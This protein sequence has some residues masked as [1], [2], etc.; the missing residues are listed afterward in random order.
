MIP[1]VDNGVGGGSAAASPVD[2]VGV[3]GCFAAC[4]CWSSSFLGLPRPLLMIPPVDGDGDGPSL[5]SFLG[6]PRPRHSLHKPVRIQR[7]Q[8]WFPSCPPNLR[9]ILLLR[10]VVCKHPTRRDPVPKTFSSSTLGLVFSPPSSTCCLGTTTSFCHVSKPGFKARPALSI[11]HHRHNIYHGLMVLELDSL[12]KRSLHSRSP[13]PSSAAA[14]LYF[15]G[16][17]RPS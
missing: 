17:S 9:H 12:L 4:D 13:S 14:G 6:L 5:C 16:L 11:H 3:G 15:L 7:L 2:T 10:S 8:V 1:P